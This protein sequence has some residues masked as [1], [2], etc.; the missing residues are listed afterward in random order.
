MP[1]APG[2]AK[3]IVD[4]FSG[5]PGNW[6]A[7]GIQPEMIE[8]QMELDT[9]AGTTVW[10]K[11]RLEGNVLIEY[12][13]MVIDKNGPNDRVSD[14]NCFWMA[15]D[16]TGPYSFSNVSFQQEITE[17]YYKKITTIWAK[18]NSTII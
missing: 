14:L 6:L 4:D 10:F 7:E 8:Y 12:E 9:P 5:N 3:Y 11:P 2:L 13:V 1:L 18:T 17:L 15:T 16:P